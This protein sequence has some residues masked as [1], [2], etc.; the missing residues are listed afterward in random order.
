MI[1]V[2]VKKK[3]GLANRRTR[4]I[5]IVAA[6]AFILLAVTISGVV[7]SPS[8]YQTNFAEKNLAPSARHIF[9]T[10][11]MGRDMF[12]RTIKGLATSIYIGLAASVVSAFLALLLGIIA[13]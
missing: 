11:W 2:P 7:M 12:A 3:R 6:A 10:D 1:K 4:T 8:A 13:R 9:G 5:V